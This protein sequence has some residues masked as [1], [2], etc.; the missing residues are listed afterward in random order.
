MVMSR[1]PAARHPQ[2][3]APLPRVRGRLLRRIVWRA[4]SAVC[5]GGLYPWR[6][7]DHW[8]HIER[9]PMP[10]PGLGQGFVGRTLAHVSDLHLCPIVRARYLQ[11]FIDEI[12]RLRPDFVAITGDLVT[13]SRRAARKVARLIDGLRPRIA[14][15][16][17]LGNHDYGV[18]HPGLGPE[19]SLADY[20]SGHLLDRGVR[21]MNNH[22]H[23]FRRDGA[24]LQFVGVEDVW[25]GRCD[26]HKAFRTIDPNRPVIALTHNPDAAPQLAALGAQWV[27]AGHTHGKD[28]RGRLLR[29][30]MVPSTPR[31]FVA[32]RYPLD[33]GKF[34]YV[35]RGLA[36][37]PRRRAHDKP[38]ITLFTLCRAA[39]NLCA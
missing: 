30:A 35:N 13:G 38:E 24:V 10:L 28:T 3:T 18:W 7:E 16:A 31:H 15:L 29:R 21:L 9:T 17:C 8:F 1:S 37:S 4:A 2:Q 11:R 25:T 36:Q 19:L 26:P 22:S 12:N 34:L 39:R 32:G 23:S 27:L 5:L 33:G 20:L 14:T 6:L